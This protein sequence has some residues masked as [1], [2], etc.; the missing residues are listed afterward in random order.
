MICSLLM[1]Q[2][3]NILDFTTIFRVGASIK[4]QKACSGTC[5]PNEDMFKFKADFSI[6]FRLVQPM[7]LD[8]LSCSKV[9]LLF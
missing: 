2:F 7:L 5:C 6:Q 3:P 9:L 1:G 8:I 4:S